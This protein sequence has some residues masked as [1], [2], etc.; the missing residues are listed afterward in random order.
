VC[1]LLI[2][3]AFRDGAI[4][5]SGIAFAD[6]LPPVSYFTPAGDRAIKKQVVLKKLQD[7]FSRFYGICP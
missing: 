3:G 7:F 1:L 4:Q 2:E 6:I 5:A